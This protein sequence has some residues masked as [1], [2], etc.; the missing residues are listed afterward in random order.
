MSKSAE[1]EILE[2]I[3]ASCAE[4]LH[5]E[6]LVDAKGHFIGVRLWKDVI[7]DDTP[8]ET[9]DPLVGEEHNHTWG[10]VPIDLNHILSTRPHLPST[11][12]VPNSG[13]GIPRRVHAR[14][15]FHDVG[16][17]VKDVT[18]LANNLSCLSGG[19]KALYYMH[20][21][22]WV[23][24]DFSVR[25]VIWVVDNNEGIGKLGDFEK[26]RDTNLPLHPPFRMNFLHD[27]ES[28]WWAFTWIFFYHTD[29]DTTNAN[30]SFD[31]LHAQWKQF[32]LAFPGMVG[33]PSRQEF[34]IFVD[35][36]QTVCD[37][38]LSETCRDVCD[39]I[40]HFAGTLQDGYRKAELASA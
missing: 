22:G 13:R 10:W 17:A 28:V 7:I 33:H 3:L 9:L 12:D 23:H 37:D 30:H 20:K 15:V 24:R 2:N 16:V 27:I 19:L 6:E 5:A 4:K 11:G 29:M 32:Q 36:L 14:T 18:S 34:F 26:P 31:A 35:E 1:G 39:C 40:P 21:A 38:V 8:D 25:N